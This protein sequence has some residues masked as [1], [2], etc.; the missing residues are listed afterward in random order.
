M[1]APAAPWP[2]KRAQEWKRQL[3]VS[4]CPIERMVQRHWKLCPR[5]WQVDAIRYLVT[6]CTSPE[7][8]SPRLLLVRKTGEGKTIVLQGAATILGGVSLCVVPLHTLA[9]DQVVR[10]NG[11]GTIP[12]L[13]PLPK[14]YCVF[15][16]TVP[17]QPRYY[18]VLVVYL[19]VD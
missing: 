18:R 2:Q 14:F 17:L 1:A 13:P 12:P 4:A 6:K 16:T 8:D 7:V 9:A 15:A 5:D 3:L 19:Q 10:A 11:H